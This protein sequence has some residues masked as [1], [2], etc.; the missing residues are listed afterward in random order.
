MS[1]L[2][3]KINDTDQL[4]ENRAF[5]FVGS[6]TFQWQT[7]QPAVLG[8]PNTE[9]RHFELSVAALY[10]WGLC[11]MPPSDFQSLQLNQVLLSDKAYREVRMP[12]G[13]A[14]HSHGWLVGVEPDR[15]LG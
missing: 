14:F 13:A 11:P 6:L 4:F 1:H 12:C 2:V 3:L 5:V 9:K 15:S 8:K 7:S 10:C